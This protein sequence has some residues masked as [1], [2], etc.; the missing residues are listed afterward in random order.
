MSG[1][2]RTPG[3]GAAGAKALRCGYVWCVEDQPEGQ[4]AEAGG[5]GGAVTGNGVR[6]VAGGHGKNR[7]LF[8][9][10]GEP[11]RGFHVGEEHE[12]NQG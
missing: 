9:V 5:G 8:W 6:E 3:K 1:R 12:S 10:K 7:I 2:A 4:M 11:I